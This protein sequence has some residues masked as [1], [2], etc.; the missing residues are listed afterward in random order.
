MI[1]EVRGARIVQ[2]RHSTGE[3]AY[4]RFRK[5]VRRLSH[6]LTATSAPGDNEEG[7]GSS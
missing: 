4:Y 2:V 7:L 3:V 6:D 5:T 1:R